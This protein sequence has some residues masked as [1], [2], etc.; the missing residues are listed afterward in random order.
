M[1]GVGGR[2]REEKQEGGVGL[3]SLWLWIL[4]WVSGGKRRV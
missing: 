4:F 1:L 2:G 3:S